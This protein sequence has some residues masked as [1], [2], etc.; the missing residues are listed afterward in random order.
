MYQITKKQ[1]EIGSF[2]LNFRARYVRS[3]SL[4]ELARRFNITHQTI[5]GHL[6]RME[7]KGLLKNRV[8]TRKLK[9]EY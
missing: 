8:P 4:R 6:E 1:K 7:A 9:D 3:P 2:I 5:Y